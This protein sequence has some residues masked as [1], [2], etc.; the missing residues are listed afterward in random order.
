[1]VFLV[2]VGTDSCL[3]RTHNN[4]VS[5][6]P[7]GLHAKITGYSLRTTCCKLESSL[8]FVR[9]SGV[10]HYILAIKPRFLYKYEMLIICIF[11]SGTNVFIWK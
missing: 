1:M 11:K 9:I 10:S 8:N 4:L 3:L 6:L 2:N 7:L 5:I